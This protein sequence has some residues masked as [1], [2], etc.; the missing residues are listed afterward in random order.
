MSSHLPPV[1]TLRNLED[2]F[3]LCQYSAGWGLV[4]LHKDWENLRNNFSPASFLP[5]GFYSSCLNV[6]SRLNLDK[7][8]LTAKGIYSF[9]IKVNSSPQILPHAWVPFPSFQFF[10]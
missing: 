8:E 9:L 6:L 3:F 1:T 5:P 4:C 10:P 2:K 7:V